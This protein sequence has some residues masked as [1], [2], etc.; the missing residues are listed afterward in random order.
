MIA[1]NFIKHPSALLAQMELALVETAG[2]FTGMTKADKVTR[3]H[4]YSIW[5]YQTP[6]DEMPGRKTPKWLAALKAAARRLANAV[7][8]ACV[9]LF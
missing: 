6:H 9:F 7:R 1:R 2:I 8:A 3:P 4:L 5:T